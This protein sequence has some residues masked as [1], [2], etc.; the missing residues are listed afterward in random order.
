VLYGRG[1][2]KNIN[3]TDEEHKVLLD[4][5]NMVD[6]T[7]AYENAMYASL[8]SPEADKRIKLFWL[9]VRKVRK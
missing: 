3:L 7:K 9:V 5:L 4:C 6:K 2:V 8:G 1:L